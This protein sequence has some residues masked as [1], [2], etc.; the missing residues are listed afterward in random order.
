MA[1]SPP[2]SSLI[3]DR[4]PVI[5]FEPEETVPVVTRHEWIVLG[6][7]GAIAA[8]VLLLAILVAPIVLL[9]GGH[10]TVTSNV[11]SPAP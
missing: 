6:V 7:V 5:T 10:G 2:P 9:L 1:A 11:I 4:G 3:A 8:V